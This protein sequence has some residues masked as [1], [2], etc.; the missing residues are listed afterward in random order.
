VDHR[1]Q[2]A[3]FVSQPQEFAASQT[4]NTS[5][6]RPD[7]ILCRAGARLFGCRSSK[8][9][10]ATQ[11]RYITRGELSLIVVLPTSPRMAVSIFL[12]RTF[13]D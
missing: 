13:P 12:L 9:S 1:R 11:D 2:K 8:I 6:R 3:G 4:T 5:H 7:N 10:C